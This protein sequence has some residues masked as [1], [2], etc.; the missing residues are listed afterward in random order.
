[1]QFWEN[2]LDVKMDEDQELWHAFIEDDEILNLD[3][4][5]EHV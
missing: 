1:V 2:K 4:I 3:K 5:K